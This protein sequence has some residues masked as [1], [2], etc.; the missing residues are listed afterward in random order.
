MSNKEPGIIEVLVVGLLRLVWGWRLEIGAVIATWYAW[1]GLGQLLGAPPLAL[2]PW[3]AALTIGPSRRW[4]RRLEHGARV[5]RQ[6]TKG[7]RTADITEFNGWLPRVLRTVEVPAGDTLQVAVPPHGIVAD[8]EDAAEIIAARLAVSEVRVT[9]DPGN[10]QLATVVLVRRDPLAGDQAIVW[11]HATAEALS[12]WDPIPVGVDENGKQITISLAERNMLLGGEPG[13]GKSAALSLLVATAALDPTVDLWLLDG[14]LVELATWG[15]CATHSVGTS[16]AEAVGVL[17]QLQTEME[18][19]YVQ[20]LATRRRKVVRGDG[21]RL[22][23]RRLRRTGPLPHRPRPQ[24]ADG[25]RR[26]APRPREPWT[27]R[28]R[29]RPR[30]HAEAGG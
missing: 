12:L 5:R 9:R 19:R 24:R 27:G 16:T 8:L 7:I 18:L 20:L 4:L 25:V 22:Q 30:R 23:G 2:V 1:W 21:H 28:R 29:H 17:R 13:A 11:P 6:L 14:K 3:A 15:G 10:A 26:G